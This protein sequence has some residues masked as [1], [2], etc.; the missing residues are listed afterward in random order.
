MTSNEG[1]YQLSIIIPVRNEGRFL[2]QTLDQVYLQDYPMDAV[3][4]V[5]V[6]GGMVM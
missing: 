5:V 4:V 1:K 2:G 6:D 3:E